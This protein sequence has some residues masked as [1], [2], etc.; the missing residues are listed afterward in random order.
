[1]KDDK[2]TK[3]V[4]D[5]K[6]EL[7]DEQLKGAAGGNSGFGNMA[8]TYLCNDCGAIHVYLRCKHACIYCNSRNIQ[9]LPLHK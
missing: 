3:K 6:A 8:T 2:T 7:P 9:E 4:D 1:M 5:K